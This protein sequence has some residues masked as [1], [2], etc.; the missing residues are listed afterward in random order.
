MF[1]AYI[2]HILLVHI[3]QVAEV[4]VQ[5]SDVNTLVQEPPHRRPPI[6]Q[7]S[8]QSIEYDDT[9][10]AFILPEQLGKLPEWRT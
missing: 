4:G 2:R 5:W 3:E 8:A 9:L 7:V 10:R 6:P 1:L